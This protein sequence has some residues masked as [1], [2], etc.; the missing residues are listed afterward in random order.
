M[1]SK[2]LLLFAGFLAIASFQT[3]A[4]DTSDAYDDYSY[5]WA[6]DDS[7]K[8]K[9]TSRK[10]TNKPEP[11]IVPSDTLSPNDAVEEEII[12]TDEEIADKEKPER[13]PIS[14]FRAPM[15]S[16]GG[17]GGNFTG[18]FTYTQIGE[19][20]YV[21]LV[22]SPEF[23]FGKV[24]VGLNVPLLYG[25]ESKSIR[26]EMFKNGVGAARLIRYV[27][28]GVQKRDP[29]YVKVGELSGLMLGY[30]G[31]INNY[32]NST[33]YEKRKVG[34]H[35]DINYKRFVG[36][37]MMYSDFDP[38]S[39]NLFAARPYVRPLATLSTPIINTLEAGVSFVIDKDQTNIP[40]SDSTSTSYEFTKNGVKAFGI[41]MGITVLKS[42]FIQ[43]DVFA[44]YSKLIIKNDSLTSFAN[45]SNK[46]D[47]KTGS[48]F[49]AGTNF[50]FHFIADVFST[51]VRIERLTYTDHYLPQFFNSVYE[52]KKDTRIESLISTEKKSGIYGKLEGHVLQ[53]LT[54]GGSLL[55]PDNISET[56]PAIVQLNA[57][58]ERLADKFSMHGS[59][60][61][62]NLENLGDAFTFDENSLAKLRFIYHLNRF[63]ATGVDYYWAFTPVS[64]GSYEAT[65]YV[66]PYFGVSI[67]F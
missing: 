45:S 7:K 11:Q 54:L 39:L 53:K 42:P 18:G 33:S 35:A 57:D 41:D 52:L 51:D 63:L 20:N 12:D 25:L 64:D 14:D 17:G 1:S 5:L 24:G 16:G 43:I 37:E 8:K 55:I 34:L 59:Y 15:T 27:R 23:T 58:M 19:E 44:N 46:P 66:M 49:S 9:T 40:T 13:P 28:Y 30:G 47:F 32:S 29:V 4:Q 67:D 10:K 3:L 31:L 60:V 21:G 6:D 65:K 26:T 50:R 38:T 56:A 2:T 62:G 61:K 48:G 36:L 22:L